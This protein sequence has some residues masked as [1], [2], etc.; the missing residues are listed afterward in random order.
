MYKTAFVTP[1]G[2]YE[3]LQMPFGMVNS[4]A[5]LVG[6]LKKV[7]KG[8]SGVGSYI[9]DIVIYSDSW[10]EHLRTLKEL[11]G[12]LRRA[13]ITARP[14]KCLLGANR[15]EFLGHQVGG[16]VITPSNDN[17]EKVRKT[18]RPT[19]KK[20]VRSFLGLVNYNRD[21]MPG[22]AEISAPL[23]DLLKKGKPEQVQWN[24]T[25]ERACS[26]LKYLLQ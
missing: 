1:D 20:Q 12:R 24:K 18:P 4:G 22:F 5:T 8:L 21:H 3:F 6:E 23:S 7:L 16:D 15:M 14:R 10:E 13:R 26:L 25:Q 17:L 11:F 19:T 9:D 2:Q